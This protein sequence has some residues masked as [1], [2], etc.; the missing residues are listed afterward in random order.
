M[1][2]VN[3]YLEKNL[4]HETLRQVVQQSIFLGIKTKDRSSNL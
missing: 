2:D 4:G 1:R 3:F